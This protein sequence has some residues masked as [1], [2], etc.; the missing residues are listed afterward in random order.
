[1]ADIFQEHFVLKYFSS[2]FTTHVA[3]SDPLLQRH[4]L[5]GV[6]HYV[7][8]EFDCISKGNMV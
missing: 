5:I 1:L 2:P 7:I 3:Y 4:N 8:A 6:F